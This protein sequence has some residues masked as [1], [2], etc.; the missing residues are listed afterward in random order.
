[1]STPN[2]RHGI[3]LMILVTLIFAAQDGVSRHLGDS[4]D[5]RMVVMI[6][7]WFFAAFALFLGYRSTGSVFGGLRTTQPFVQAFRSLLIVVEICLMLMSFVKVGL[8]ESH[9]IFAVYPLLIAAL[10]GPF[11]GES[12]GWR[13]WMAIGIGFS[14]VL[15]ILQPSDG[16][17]SVHSLWAVSAALLF[18][19]YGLMNRFAARKDSS[20]TSF[21]W[22]GVFGGI[23]M[24]AIGIWYWMPMTPVDW[25]WMLA[26]CFVGVIG[27]Y[28][29]IRAYEVAE[30]SA[31]QPFAYFQLPFASGIGV[32]VFNDA[33][34]MNVVI[35]AT[36]VVAA[37]V[38]ALVREQ[39]SKRRTR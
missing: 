14:G 23:A 5:V 1:M 27:H 30:A 16:V 39:I 29:L 17:F 13:R 21:V 12:V 34:R 19:L 15:I 24:T 25:I 11:L 26:L 9:A 2:N 6:R 8:V 35:G 36:I 28:L 38:F 18:A 37:G 22:M 33:L 32:L 10:S 3:I 31:I 4:Y 20:L 7:F